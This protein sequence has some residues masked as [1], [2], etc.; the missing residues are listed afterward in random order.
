[1]AISDNKLKEANENFG[2]AG[3][4]ANSSE[5]VEQR[6]YLAAN[7]GIKG[8]EIVEP[9]EIV[10]ARNLFYRDG[11]VVVQNLLNAEQLS[12]IRSGCDR[13]IS[14]I[15]QLD[16]E[17]SGNRGS[18][19]YSFGSS[20]VT[21]QMSHHP[22]WAMLLDLPKLDT[23]L[24]A[25]FNSEDY[26][27]R[28]A[29]GDFCL[30]GAV[31]YQP[32]HSDMGD[33]HEHKDPAS[34][35]TIYKSGSF[36][37]PRGILNYRDLPCPFVACNFP[38]VD[39]T[40]INGPTR[41]I[42]GTQHSREPVPDLES[43]PA[44]MK[45]STV[46]P[47]PAGSG[48]IRDVRAWHGGTPNLSNETRAIPNAEYFAPWFRQNVR[49]SLPRELFNSLSERG[50]RISREIVAPLGSTLKLGYRQNLGGTPKGF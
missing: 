4:D 38:M 25:I 21:G 12:M 26:I 41:Q 20:S 49:P 7:N 24:S 50:Q 22:E 30:P 1:M 48:V 47:V 23:I 17:R 45:L 19:R 31:K 43:E 39:F 46:C 18:H 15:M 11:F 10:R 32:L 28:G 36:Q 9:D 29:G 35:E 8:L 40:P 42:P 14:E 33:Y 13:V 6:K 27:T 3:L 37:D 5:F 16:A 34:G 2:W 44:W